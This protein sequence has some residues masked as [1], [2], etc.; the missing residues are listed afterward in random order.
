MCKMGICIVCICTAKREE[1]KQEKESE[2]V[3]KPSY[4]L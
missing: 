3:G 2:E 1:I 4:F